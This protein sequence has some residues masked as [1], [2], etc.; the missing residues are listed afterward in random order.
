MQLYRYCS[1][2]KVIQIRG[3]YLELKKDG[4]WQTRMALRTCNVPWKNTFTLDILLDIING[5]TSPEKWDGQISV[6]LNEVH[7][8]LLIGMAQENGFTISKLADLFNTLP[9]LLQSCQ[10]KSFFYDGI[11]MEEK[12]C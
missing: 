10:A 7:P 6:L 11:I 5:K 1:I 4:K 9:P 8:S 3:R 12:Y 2:L